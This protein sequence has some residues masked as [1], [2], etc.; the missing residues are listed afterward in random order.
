MQTTINQSVIPHT[1]PVFS[2]ISHVAL[3]VKY[4][5]KQGLSKGYWR[6]LLKGKN[7]SKSIPYCF[8]QKIM[9]K[10][11]NQKNSGT[12]FVVIKFELKSLCLK[13]I[14]ENRGIGV[15]SPLL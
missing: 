15:N 10:L 4:H 5:P 3:V 2:I 7:L 9:P 11:I 6:G 14:G 8:H 12:F 13:G 1:L